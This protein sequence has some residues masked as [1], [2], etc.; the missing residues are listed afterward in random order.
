MTEKEALVFVIT[1]DSK[2]ECCSG[3]RRSAETQE[4]IASLMFYFR[5]PVQ[6]EIYDIF[7]PHEGLPLIWMSKTTQNV[8]NDCSAK[9]LEYSSSDGE[10]LERLNGGVAAKSSISQ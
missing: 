5:K 2:S 3:R 4:R 9:H 7:P 6:C 10:H 8:V 1:V